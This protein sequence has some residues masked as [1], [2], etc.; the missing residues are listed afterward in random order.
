MARPRKR[1]Y[2][3]KTQKLINK[4]VYKARPKG[5]P[6]KNSEWNYKT[7][8]YEKALPRELLKAANER[9]RKLEKVSGLSKSSEMYQ[10]MSKYAESYPKTKGKIY[11]QEALE[12]GKLRFINKTKF[13]KLSADEKEY[14]IERLKRF[15]ESTTTTKLGIK[16]AHKQSY[17]TFMKRYGKKFPNLTQEQYEEFFKAYNYNVVGDSEDHFE[18]SEWSKVLDNIKID[19]VMTDREMETVMQYVRADDWLGLRNSEYAKYLTRI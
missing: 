16:A 17:D 6:P 19:E 7:G 1:K 3:S 15:M 9:L 13:D 11:D 10:L 2:I 12:Q 14:Y 5:R 8:Q 18:Y 4:G